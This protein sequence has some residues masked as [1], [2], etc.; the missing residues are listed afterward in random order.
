MSEICGS[1]RGYR[2]LGA[3]SLCP[4]CSL[5]FQLTFSS[6]LPASP[7]SSGGLAGWSFIHTPFANNTILYLQRG[8]GG[9][10]TLLPIFARCFVESAARMSD[11]ISAT[12]LRAT[13]HECTTASRLFAS[14]R[15]LHGVGGYSPIRLLVYMHANCVLYIRHIDSNIRHTDINKS[16]NAMNLTF[17]STRKLPLKYPPTQ[18]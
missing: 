12:T 17:A 2:T 4:D 8:V 11:S 10:S 7:P 5:L 13:S 14:R 3:S 18:H 1:L 15:D 6:L 16:N 9:C